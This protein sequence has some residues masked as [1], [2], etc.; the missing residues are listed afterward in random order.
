MQCQGY[1]KILQKKKQMQKKNGNR[2]KHS[3]G[4]ILEK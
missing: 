3:Y 1:N 2:N 4:L